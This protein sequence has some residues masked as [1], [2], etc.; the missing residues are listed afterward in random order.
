LELLQWFFG[1]RSRSDWQS[2]WSLTLTLP[3][4]I[5][6]GGVVPNALRDA[7]VAR[8]EKTVEGIVTA[9]EPSN[10]NQCRYS[11]AFDGRLF[12]GMGSSP[13]NT[14]TVGQHVTVF[15]DPNRPEINSLEGFEI[16]KKRQ[17]GMVPFCGIGICAVV[18]FVMYSKLRQSRR[19]A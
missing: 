4:F 5:A 1:K 11:F 18:G 14:A 3:L 9:Y 13:T 6:L 17:M 7:D 12:E 15:F 8:R 19:A 16:A 2:W 10:H